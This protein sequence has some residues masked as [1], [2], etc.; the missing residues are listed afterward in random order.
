MQ[1]GLPAPRTGVAVPF[2]ETSWNGTSFIVD[3]SA[4]VAVL[5]REP[6]WESL[7]GKL[8]GADFVGIGVATL[9]EA[10]MVLSSRI[11]ADARPL[12]DAFLTHTAAYMIPFEHVHYQAAVTAFLRFGKGRHPA[13]LN[14]GDCLSRRWRLG[15]GDIGA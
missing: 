15:G 13:A 7:L 11:G 14:F 6:E 8:R 2:G 3:T 10:A 12:L 5:L 4:I 1:S 9:L